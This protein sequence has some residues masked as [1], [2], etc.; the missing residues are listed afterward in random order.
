MP[1]D[2][3]MATYNGENHI[4]NQLLSLQQQTYKDWTLW[5]RDDGSNDETNRIVAEFAALDNRI[6]IVREQAGLRLGP[7]KN[8][9]GL[10]RY[11]KSEYVIFCD[12]DDI[13]FEKKLEKL[14]FFAEKNF[15]STKP[16]LVMCD[17]YGYSDKSGTITS[18]RV[19]LW[20]AKNLREFL[21]FNAGYQG[22]NVLF[23]RALTEYLATYKGG[24]FY[25][26][27]DVT[28]LIAH[29]FGHVF[30]MSDKLMLYRQ[31]ERNVTGNITTSILARL[32]LFFRK[33]AFVISKKHYLEKEAFFNSYCDEMNP[34]DRR[35]FAEYLSFPRRSLTGRIFSLARNRFSLGGQHFPLY[36][37]TVLRRPLE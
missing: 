10:S 13:W 35:L 32:K 12:Q 18:D 21:F 4:R 24:Y 15:S 3:L 27:D 2:I 19:W 34:D 7:G 26:H 37:K 31:H 5:V 29:T 17:G 6:N 23:N 22:C 8:F 9:V 25:M 16:C 36:L 30:F 28:S 33:D 20:Y 14:V 1:V 11:A